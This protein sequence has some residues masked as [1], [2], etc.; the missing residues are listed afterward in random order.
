M[1]LTVCADR[2]SAQVQSA[3]ELTTPVSTVEVGAGAVSDGSYKAGEY[4]GLEKKGGFLIGN[5]DCAAAAA[6]DSDSALR[7]RDQGHRPRAARPAACRPRS[8]CR[9]GSD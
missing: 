1:A 3:A 2:V 4:N 9:A 7:W 5:I 6:Y 8:A